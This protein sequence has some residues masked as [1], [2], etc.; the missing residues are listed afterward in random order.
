MFDTM[1]AAYELAQTRGINLTPVQLWWLATQGAA[2]ALHLQHEV[3]NIAPGMA[4]DLILIDLGSTP[5]IAHRMDRVGSIIEALFVQI[6]LADD[7]AIAEV[8][9]NGKKIT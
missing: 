4:A 1:K 7:R 8:W 3:G 9:A 6:I 2:R 5:L